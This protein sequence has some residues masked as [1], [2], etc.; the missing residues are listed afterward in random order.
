M[1][2]THL[3]SNAHLISEISDIYGLQQLIT[4]P[5]RITGSLSSLI[6]VTFINYINRVLCS[7]VLH[8]G[9]SDHSLIYIYSKLSPEFAF[10]GHSIKTY[11]NFCNLNRENFRRDISRQDWSYTSDDPDV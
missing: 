4:K 9:I 10:K 1:A 11:R 6:N 3:E 7:R 2:S 8:V 5:T